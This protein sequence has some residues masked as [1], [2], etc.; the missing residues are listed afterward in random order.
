MATKKVKIEIDGNSRNAE[1]ALE[2]TSSKL[3]RLSTSF[4]SAGR[5]AGR[6]AAVGVAAATVAMVALVKRSLEVE[7]RLGKVSDALGINVKDLAALKLA[8]SLAGVEFTTLQ[9]GMRTMIKSIGDFGNNIGLAKDAFK[10]FGLTFEQLASL[11]PADQLALIGE[12]ISELKT[13]TEKVTVAQQI[14]GGRAFELLNVLKLLSGQGL[15]KVRTETEKLGV[16]LSREQIA[17]LEAVNDAFTRANTAATGLGNTIAL[18]LSKELTALGNKLADK[19]P[20]AGKNVSIL[21]LKLER[22]ALEAKIKLADL[23]IEWNLFWD[24]TKEAAKVQTVADA[25]QKQIAELTTRIKALNAEKKSGTPENPRKVPTGTEIH[26]NIPPPPDPKIQAQLAAIQSSLLTEEDRIKQSYARRAQIVANA[27]AVGQTSKQKARELEIALANKFQT[28]LTALEKR[29]SDERTRIAKEEADKKRQT[30]EQGVG[31][32]ADILGSASQLIGT[33][34]KKDFKESQKFAIAQAIV[35]GAL[36]VTRAL[37]SADPPVNFIEAAAVAAAAAVQIKTIRSQT[38]GGGGA[39]GGA[40]PTFSAQPLTGFPQPPTPVEARSQIDQGRQTQSIVNF[41]INA[42][43]TQSAA[44][45]INAN[46]GQ[47]VGIIQ[48]SYDNRAAAGGPIR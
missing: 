17:K 10:K 4:A 43:D 31:A 39:A 46:R 13:N 22:G 33:Q 2:R 34:N 40:V 41:N 3:G 8:S 9:T 1:H 18:K 15:E 5:A 28:D 6:F 37:G 7:D 21:F 36:G 25:A 26:G 12:K 19:I 45:V 35:S 48:S 29:Q 27:L 16:A 30:M 32:I 14:F 42:L 11:S 47:I 24:D 23:R 44:D 20:N 38:F